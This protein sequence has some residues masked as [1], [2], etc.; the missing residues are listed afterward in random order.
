[1]LWPLFS[2]YKKK[3]CAKFSPRNRNFK[4]ALWGSQWEPSKSYWDYFRSVFSSDNKKYNFFSFFWQHCTMNNY[5]KWV[6]LKCSFH[7][8]KWNKVIL[9][10]FGNVCAQPNEKCH[11]KPWHINCNNFLDT[12]FRVQL[13]SLHA[14]FHGVPAPR[15]TRGKCLL[16]EKGYIILKDC[17]LRNGF[18]LPSIRRSE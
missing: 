5:S 2:T 13:P 14:S 16:N 15:V 4:M 12:N 10:N 8:T 17:V 11:L 1:M 18:L 6:P 9:F 7:F 3:N